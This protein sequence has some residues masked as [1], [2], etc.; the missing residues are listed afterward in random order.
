[1]LY[2]V[3]FSNPFARKS[4]MDSSVPKIEI[5]L[6]GTWQIRHSAK[7]TKKDL[8]RKEKG[9]L[10]YLA[11]ES[12][13]THSRDSLIGLFWPDLSL[14]DAR[15][16]LRVSLSR[17][18]RY[19]S[20]TNILQST[21]HEVC[22]NQNNQVHLDVHQFLLLIKQA[23]TH[24][25]RSLTACHQCQDQLKQ[26]VDL[27]RGE[28]LAGFYLEDCLAFEEWLFV[29]RE[30][31][32]VQVLAQL[33]QLVQ[34]AEVNGRFENAERYARR[35][36]ELDPLH[37]RA[38]RHLMQA[39]YA[40]G[41]RNA[42]LSKFKSCE[43]ILRDELGIEPEAET[44]HLQHK[45]RAGTL[46]ISAPALAT[47]QVASYSLPE[48]GTP[49]VGREVEL[50]QLNQRLTER[51]YR[52]I[53]LVGPG[54]IGKTRLAIQAARVHRDA[55]RD[56]VYFVPLEG[57]QN[58]SEIPAAIAEAIGLSFAGNAVSPKSEIIQ[59]LQAKQSLLIIDNLEH[60][61]DEGADLLLELL[62]LAPNIVLLVTSRERLNSQMEDLFRLR[63]LPYPESDDEDDGG[64][65]AAIRL[66]VD[67]AR[68]IN[69]AF[70]LTEANLHDVNTICRL[71]EGLP[72]GIELA[73]TWLRDFSVPQIAA[74]L[75][76]DFALL[77]TDLRDV[78]PRHRSVATVFEHSWSLLTKE[79]QAVLAQLSIFRGG[80]T[81]A[82]AQ[83]VTGASP[84]LLTRLRYKS[85]I[86]GSGNGRYTMHDLLRQLSQRKLRK[87][88]GMSDHAEAKHS[89]T[90]LTL[91]Q[92]QAD[93]LNRDDAAIASATLRPELDNIRRAW[94]WAIH[95]SA[96][97][98]LQQSTGGLAD[99]LF[100][101]GLGF[102]GAQLLQIAIEAV[103]ATGKTEG[104]LLPLLLVK[105][106]WLLG[107][108]RSYNEIVAI[109]EQILLLTDKK[110]EMVH[111]EA[112][113]YLLWA[114]QALDQIA[115]PK[116]AQRYLDEAAAIVDKLDNSELTAQLLCDYGRFFFSDG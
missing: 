63:G 40:Q 70:G 116:Q 28:F 52:L 115:D 44:V 112:Q 104:S 87:F 89:R 24:D 37:E 95:H 75:Q 94:R 77:E 58:A 79:E 18:K 83:A 33:D 51:N 100:H 103:Q 5:S 111:L 35:E 21:R 55:F 109:I 102:E 53:S 17:L 101:G 60:L 73:A 36:L 22:L 99:F 85:L 71:V 6:I 90:Y 38:H 114:N 20:D 41:K 48:I 23:E 39:L 50:D 13:Q 3:Q 69:K 45:I 76:E 93:R 81:M 110:P 57:V 27:Y 7:P 4:S 15:N 56:G 16:N 64:R 8:R 42:A 86:R 32:H 43:S 84:L 68:R 62:R 82:A 1:M 97:D 19:L 91:L 72:L 30:R 74:S 108:F 107:D 49:F 31:L 106:A 80:F 2:C 54:G 46:E 98:L 47:N 29:W 105:Q 9:L 11:V 26:A 61:I 34:V 67:R 66:F 10:A 88:D 78:S 113:A 65:Y 59:A 92:E 25:H 12:G 14:S 96:F